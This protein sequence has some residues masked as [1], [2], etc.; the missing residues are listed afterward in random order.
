[1]KNYDE[2]PD[3]FFDENYMDLFNQQNALEGFHLHLLEKK[4]IDKILYKSIKICEKN[5]FWNF[6]TIQTK[7]DMIKKTYDHLIDLLKIE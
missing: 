3:D 2:E 6:Y 7:L 5:I 1:M 4:V